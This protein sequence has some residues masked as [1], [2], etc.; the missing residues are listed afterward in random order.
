MLSCWSYATVNSYLHLMAIF[1]R[2]VSVAVSRLYAFTHTLR[3]ILRRLR[4]VRKIVDIFGD[5]PAG[6]RRVGEVEDVRNG[7]EVERRC[8]GSPCSSIGPSA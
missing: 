7:N 4:S 3:P 5:L 8:L 6:T 2:H 1:L